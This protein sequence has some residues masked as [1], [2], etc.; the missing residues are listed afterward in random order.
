MRDKRAQSRDGNQPP[1]AIV[2]M[3]LVLILTI[4]GGSLRFQDLGRDSLWYDEAF[5]ALQAQLP[6]GEL[7]QSVAQDVHPPLYHLLLH[8]VLAFGDSEV[9]LRIPSALFGTLS[10]PL[11]YLLG[12]AWFSGPVG[13]LAALLLA[14]SPAHI[15]HSQDARMYT[16]L[17]FEGILAWYFF[18]RL[19]KAPRLSLWV[20]YFLVA[21]AIL[22]THYYGV[23]LLLPQTGVVLLLRHRE[24]IGWSFWSRWVRVQ[25]GL[26][27]V[28]LPWISFA[29]PTI[30]FDRVSWIGEPGRPSPLSQAGQALAGFGVGGEESSW[31]LGI[32]F[33]LLSMVGLV[34]GEDRS[35]RTPRAG[36]RERPILLCAAYFAAPILAI[37]AISMVRPLLVPRYVL[38]TV[39]A[40]FLMAAVGLSRLL[41]DRLLIIGATSLVLFISPGLFHYLAVPRTADYRGVVALIT[42]EAVPGDL[43]LFSPKY[44][45][46][47]FAYYVRGRERL[48]R[49][50]Q[51]GRGDYSAGDIQRCQRGVGRVWVVSNYWLNQPK[52]STLLAS[53]G[54]D[55]RVVRTADFFRARV[56]L[57]ERRS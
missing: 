43:M 5:S 26:A 15:W 18:G 57:L 55:F 44:D 37:L 2:E 53:L 22:Y 51:S 11:L 28:F 13:V 6:F 54:E 47:L 21:E 45:R 24:E 56:T 3:A 42:A 30:R 1:R 35:W 9:A 49:W 48:F 25:T 34:R 33:L 27:L 10:I 19:L 12:R 17:T 36:L 8:G 52:E 20:G 23:L 41:P 46:T 32:P 14:I 50:C 7:L 31:L 29:W 38:M 16:L 39:P 4:A 40:F